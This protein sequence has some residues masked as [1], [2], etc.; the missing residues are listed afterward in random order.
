M[1]LESFIL[2]I[3]GSIPLHR[4]N[5]TSVL[6]RR[7]GEAFLFDCGEGMQV[8]LRIA[9]V[10]WKSMKLVCISHS[11]ADH[12]TGLP[13][14]LML[15]SQV[16]R[17]EPLYIACPLAVKQ[18]IEVTISTLEIYLNYEIRFIV[19][20]ELKDD[21]VYKEKEYTIRTFKG[22]HTRPVWGFIFEEEARVGKFYPEKAKALKIPQGLLW[23]RL[24]HGESIVH[25]DTTIV[26]SDV[27]GEARKGRKVSYVM[28]TRPDAYI[29]S[30]ISNSDMVFCESMFKH[31]HQDQAI[32]KKHMTAIEAATMIA[33]A[34]RVQQA[35]LLHFSPRYTYSELKNIEAEA[36]TVFP[37][38]FVCKE[39][40]TINI[41]YRD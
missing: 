29:S 31:E 26:P 5:L 18:F 6:L 8:G 11:H 32:E 17:D 38:A 9:S 37:N 25:N 12:V 2:G 35:G 3:G 19:L 1:V 21:I 10:K 16:N 13:G 24:Q 36:K 27:L 40:S 20:E 14:F 15:S 23:A 34:G 4:R 41:P 33:N 22:N 30:C 39:H 28:D 7:E